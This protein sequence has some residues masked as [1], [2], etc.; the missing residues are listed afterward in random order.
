[1]SLFLFTTDCL[2]KDSLMKNTW[3]VF[4]RRQSWIW[5]L[6]EEKKQDQVSGYLYSK[7]GFQQKY[8]TVKGSSVTGV[9]SAFPLPSLTFW[10]KISTYTL[11]GKDSKWKMIQN[12]TYKWDTLSAQKEAL[13]ND[14]F[15]HFLWHLTQ[16][17]GCWGLCSWFL[18]CC[19]KGHGVCTK[20]QREL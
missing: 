10:T 19:V 13:N 16:H 5:S 7:R 11:L 8:F 9:I 3:T 6:Q 18:G 20:I 17:T 12:L 15:F 14:L 1:M 2:I 4:D